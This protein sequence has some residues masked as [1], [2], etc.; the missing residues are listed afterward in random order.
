LTI[1]AAKQEL[2]ENETVTVRA[3]GRYSDDSE[4]AVTSGI[5]WRLSNPSVASVDPRGKLIAERPGR[6]E[7]VARAEGL[8]SKPLSVYVKEVRKSVDPAARAAANRERAPEKVFSAKD[9][10]KALV[11]AHIGRARNLREQGNYAGALSELEKAR[12]I[13]AGDEAVRKEIEQTK[14]ACSA[15]KVLGNNVSC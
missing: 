3:R 8:S 10:T 13:D 2:S 1:N 5:E 14:R 15:E 4:K 7:V 12:A 6:T 11:L 9:E